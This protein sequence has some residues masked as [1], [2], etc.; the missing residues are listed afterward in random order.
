MNEDHRDDAQLDDNGVS[1]YRD[2]LEAELRGQG[3]E[4]GTF[5][6]TLRR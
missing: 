1:G 4:P 3:L 6:Q 5:D 2:P